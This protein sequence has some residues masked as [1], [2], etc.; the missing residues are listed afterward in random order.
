MVD[1][2]KSEF[3]M[4]KQSEYF[5]AAS[6]FNKHISSYDARHD[7]AP[8]GWDCYCVRFAKKSLLE[9]S[10]SNNTFLDVGAGA[11]RFASLIKRHIP[12]LQVTALDPSV[13]LLSKSEDRSIRKVVGKIPDLPFNLKERFFF[14]H[15]ECVFHHVVEQ[16]ISESREKVKQSL[17]ALRECLADSGFLMIEEEY[18][19]TYVFAGASRTLAF[20]LLKIA[21]KLDIDVPWFLN[22]SDESLRG[23]I[24]CMYTRSELKN[25]VRDCSFELVEFKDL[26]FNG[27]SPY[28]QRFKKLMFLK[29]SG[30]VLL[31]AKKSQ[32]S[33]E[34]T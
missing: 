4:K 8:G 19:E 13:N 34:G 17:L 18:W 16:T 5:D 31:I 3:S 33:S 2:Q 32:A 14:I 21:R 12:Y 22:P 1:N 23:L 7:V 6:F 15:V 28:R 27:S 9:G 29:R 11:G 10:L 26:P 30:R 25:L 24:V 20:L